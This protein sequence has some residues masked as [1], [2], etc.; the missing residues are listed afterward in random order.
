MEG[1]LAREAE[2][3]PIVRG[4]VELPD[5]DGA[6]AR[7]V[8]VNE[9]TKDGLRYVVKSSHLTIAPHFG[10]F[11]AKHSPSEKMM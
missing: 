6:S 11:G 1:Q 5:A 7:V 10:A 2:W 3:V 4:M 9:S 8:E